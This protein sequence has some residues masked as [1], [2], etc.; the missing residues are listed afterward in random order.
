M[1][2]KIEIVRVENNVVL[3]S[4]ASNVT[5]TIVGKGQYEGILQGT[6]QGNRTGM[7]I[8]FVGIRLQMVIKPDYT[9]DS[10]VYLI[11]HYRI[12]IYAIK[13]LDGN[14]TL[15]NDDLDFLPKS[16]HDTMNRDKPVGGY[17]EKRN[18]VILSD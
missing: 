6:G 10:N 8:H 2:K 18:L 11:K 12:V 1:S 15:A 17:V 7:S 16:Y 5:Q 14:L 3:T 9:L 13:V 4:V